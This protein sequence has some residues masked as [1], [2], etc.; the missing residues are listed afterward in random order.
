MVLS[1]LFLYFFVLFFGANPDYRDWSE[2]N[3]IAM[4]FATLTASVLLH[5]YWYHIKEQQ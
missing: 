5:A 1:F 3:K 4:G 2:D